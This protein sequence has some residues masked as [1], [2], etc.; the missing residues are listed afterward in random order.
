MVK[1]N[2]FKELGVTGSSQWGR[3][4]FVETDPALVGNTAIE[5]YDKIR[6]DDSTGMMMFQALALPVRGVIWHVK[7]GGETDADREAADFVQSVLDDMVQPFSEFISDV[8]LMFCYGWA[9]FWPVLKRRTPRTS[10]FPDGRV[11]IELLEMVNPRA[12]LEWDYDDSGHFVGARVATNDM[13]DVI[14]PISESVF[15]RTSSEGGAPDGISIYRAAVRPWQYKRRLEQVEGI[16][17]YRRWAGFPDVEL[18]PGATTR[19]DVVDGEISDEERGEQLVQAIYEDKMM[20]AVRPHG[21]VLNFGGPAG[22]VDTT[23]GDTIIRK[24][25]EMSR[26]I[27]AQFMLQGLRSVG[28]QS[29]AATLQDVF[30]LSVDAY[31]ETIRAE[32][33]DAVVSLLLRWND[34]P[35]L[36]AAPTLEYTSPRRLDLNAVAKYIQALSGVNL[37]TP[38]ETL[39][40]FLRSLVPGMPT[41]VPQVAEEGTAPPVAQDS[42]HLTPEQEK[43]VGAEA[44]AVFRRFFI[45]G[46][47][48]SF[49]SVPPADSKAAQ[50][51][52]LANANA[53]TQRAGIEE[54]TGALAGNIANLPE[55]TAAGDLLAKLDDYILAALLLFR[56]RSMLDIA[57]A[58][59]LGFGAPSGP[60]EALHALEAEIDLADQWLGYENGGLRRTNPLG[61]PTLFGDIAGTLEGQIVALLLL[62]KQGRKDEVLGLVTEAVKTA[63]GGFH[64]PE[65]Y[66][67]H[68]WRGVWAG[69]VETRREHPETDGPVRWVLD[70]V[71][72]H[73][74]E[75]Q[76]YGADPP[77]REYPSMA[78]LLRFTGST[79]PGYGTECDGSC[80]CH[81]EGEVSGGWGWL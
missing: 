52:N 23:L 74:T 62:L 12:F 51:Y 13:S 50:Y 47:R 68:V 2:P 16:G 38:D 8:C 3:L 78:E 41:D 39:E 57:A 26:A 49:A 30:A 64:R 27:L 67:G 81:L 80:R 69:V 15:F 36:T 28:T 61:K 5:T 65:L 32:L 63:T 77:G 70:P 37:L 20:G 44:E 35:G 19:S 31:L 10:S 73:C 6:R 9:L 75:C 40:T 11:G 43:A 72:M 76:I 58:F 53:A 45:Q 66:A 46:G 71:A 79:L 21:W 59:W 34:F 17:L 24:D 60:P 7:P 55:D 56:E 54:W 14:V 1:P 42:E 29:L 22:N 33:N 48:Q 4:Q 25:M 18:P